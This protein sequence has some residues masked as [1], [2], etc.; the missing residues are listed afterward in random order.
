MAYLVKWIMDPLE[1]E[2]FF[3]VGGN[4]IMAMTTTVVHTYFHLGRMH[5]VVEVDIP[6]APVVIPE[7]LLSPPL[8]PWDLL[9][10]TLPD[11]DMEPMSPGLPSV[12]IL[13]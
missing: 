13:P 2:W 3:N 1:Y 10:S 6:L 4:T 9:L 7:A 5:K 12:E 8:A 11:F